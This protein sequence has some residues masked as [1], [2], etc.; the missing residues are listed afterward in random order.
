MNRVETSKGI[1]KYRNPT[2]LE[3]I[4]LVRILREYFIKED[5]I[6][7][8]LTVMENIKDLFE[9]SE[10]ND[11]KS[12]EEMNKHGEDLV[13]VVYQISDEILNKVIGAFEKKN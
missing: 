13:S 5:L 1:L 3:T 10:M 12:F 9:F 2:I 11:I 8:R 4:A 7:A 6:G